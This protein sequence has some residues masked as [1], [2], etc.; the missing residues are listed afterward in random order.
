MA[1]DPTPP[2]KQP[3]TKP[4]TLMAVPASDKMQLFCDFSP[5]GSMKLMG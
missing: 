1:K 2:L 3:L 5:V 4:A